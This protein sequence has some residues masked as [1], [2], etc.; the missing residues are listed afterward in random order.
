[1]KINVPEEV[2]TILKRLNSHGFSA[3]VVGGCV[4]D[5]ILNREPQDW[6]ISSSAMPEQVKEVFSDLGVI[7]TGIKHGTVSVII[8]HNPY[9]VTTFRCDGEY[10]DNRRPDTVTFVSDISIDLSR[11]D[12]TINAL[13]CGCEDSNEIIDLFGGIDD[14]KNGII[15]CVGEPEKRFSEDALRILRALR[16]ASVLGFNIDKKTSMAIHKQRALL[17]NISVERIMSEFKQLICGMDAVSIIR[18]FRDVIEVFIPE[19]ASMFGFSQNTPYHCYDVWEHTLHS[20]DNIEPVVDLRF[21][22]LFHDIGKPEVYSE[23]ILENGDTLGHFYAHAKYSEEIASKVLNRLKSDNQLLHD[24]KNLIRMHG[25]QIPL[26]KPAIK[27]KLNKIGI[28]LFRKLLKVKRADILAQS[29]GLVDERIKSLKDIESLLDEIISEEECF[30]LKD[31]K[32]NGRDLVELGF[33]GCEIGKTLKVI[34]DAVVDGKIDN[35]KDEIL[36]FIKT[37]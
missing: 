21:T 31:L 27:R 32:I 30:N 25:D 9:E 26:S 16:F 2:K 23:E 12:F 17:K 1:M 34:L 10:K 29:P 22:M 11:R 24:V 14:I 36:E 20:I 6:D 15:R 8:N 7:E 3:Y 13:A 18:E 37:I 19:V 33:S 35:N 5:K 4:R 28:E